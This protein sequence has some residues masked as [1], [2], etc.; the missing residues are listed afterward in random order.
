MEYQRSDSYR[1][2]MHTYIRRHEPELAKRYDSLITA[3]AARTEQG[4]PV[5]AED[6]Y[7]LARST[8]FID[9]E[10]EV[11]AVLQD[12]AADGETPDSHGESVTWPELA[13]QL[14]Y[15]TMIED[16]ERREG[17]AKRV[18]NR[19]LQHLLE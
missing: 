11:A 17:V 2:D 15:V 4:E 10:D 1:R 19:G 9:R 7:R 5:T 13:Q 3:C 6:A 16:V 14:E 18:V 8:L 12:Y